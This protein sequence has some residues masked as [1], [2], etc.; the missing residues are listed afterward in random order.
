M[1][2][3]IQLPYVFIRNGLKWIP[4]VKDPQRGD[5]ETIRLWPWTALASNSHFLF[6][7]CFGQAQTSVN[8]SVKEG[9]L[10]L[11]RCVVVRLQLDHG[12]CGQQREGL[13]RHPFRK[14]CAAQHGECGSKQPPAVNPASLP[15]LQ[16]ATWPEVTPSPGQYLVTG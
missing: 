13:P 11:Y 2:L 10:F 9:S 5:K 15:Q 8:S 7:S 1:V 12:C 6:G 3:P 16:T 4:S 14:G